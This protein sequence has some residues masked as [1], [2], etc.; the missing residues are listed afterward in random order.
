MH[1]RLHGYSFT[2]G[3]LPRLQDLGQ[4]TKGLALALGVVFFPF[5][6]RRGIFFSAC[7]TYSIDQVNQH[8]FKRREDRFRS[9]VGVFGPLPWLLQLSGFKCGLGADGKCGKHPFSN[10][11]SINAH[12]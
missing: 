3:M 8:L 7:A 9:V 12:V 10:L 6:W 2:K 1:F 11:I 5:S 4:S